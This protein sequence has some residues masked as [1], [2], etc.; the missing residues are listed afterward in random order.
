MDFFA[1]CEGVRDVVVKKVG[2]LDSSFVFKHSTVVNMSQALDARG[3]SQGFPV[4]VGG[5]SVELVWSWLSRALRS[6][7]LC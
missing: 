3:S 4:F 1:G 2:I 6:A 7:Q 5:I